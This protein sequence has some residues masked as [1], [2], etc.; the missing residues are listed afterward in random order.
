[1]FITMW[2][3]PDIPTP[4]NTSSHKE[5]EGW[6]AKAALPLSFQDQFCHCKNPTFKGYKWLA[7][8]EFP[9]WLLRKTINERI[10]CLAPVGTYCIDCLLPSKP[11]ITFTALRSCEDC[12]SYY[13]PKPDDYPIKTFL[14][15]K[16]DV[17]SLI[18]PSKK[19][20]ITHVRIAS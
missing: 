5:L 11:W 1:M 12:G 18:K 6:A 20:R 14:C 19:R 10:K 16:C 9:D 17:P 4:P 7:P 3:W 2:T 15:S 13:L 8:K